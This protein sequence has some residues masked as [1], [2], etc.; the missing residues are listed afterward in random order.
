MGRPLQVHLLEALQGVDGA[1][2]GA[3]EC[4]L[5]L[6]VAQLQDMTA[7]SVVL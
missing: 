5:V 1:V 7:L 3:A 6:V 2:D 4:V